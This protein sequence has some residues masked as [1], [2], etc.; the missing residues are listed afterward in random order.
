M[1][2][3]E[4][5]R[6]SGRTS[7]ARSIRGRAEARPTLL[8][9]AVLL[10]ASFLRADDGHRLWLRY[11]RI[12]DEALRR[13]YLGR[14]LWEELCLRYQQ[15]VDSV[16]AWQRTWEGRARCDRRRS[17]R[18]DRGAAAASGT[19]GANLARRV[20]AVFRDVLPAPAAGGRRAGRASARVLP[21]A[22]TAVHGG[23]EVTL[24]RRRR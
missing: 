15:G 18:A 16:R 22:R 3:C 13:D 23:D 5:G 6:A 21:R 9:L 17:L 4:V 7:R 1:R 10:F 14:T 11:D 8:I 12:A 24:P 20:H 2:R 19:R